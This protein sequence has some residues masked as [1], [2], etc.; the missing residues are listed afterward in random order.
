MFPPACATGL[1][2]R[3]GCFFIRQV[4]QCRR[5]FHT[6]NRFIVPSRCSF[7][8]KKTPCLRLRLTMTGKV[9]PVFVEGGIRFPDVHSVQSRKRIRRKKCTF[10]TQ[11]I[12]GYFLLRLDV[13]LVESEFVFLLQFVYK[14]ICFVYP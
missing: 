4:S 14:R 1:S 9:C 3:S 13:S 10:T 5:T 8:R 11:T 12:C 6:L 7:E 2:Q